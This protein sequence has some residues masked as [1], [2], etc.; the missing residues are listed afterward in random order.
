MEGGRGISNTSFPVCLKSLQLLGR[1][2]FPVI[3]VWLNHI[4]N[5][6]PAR[7]ASVEGL[8]LIACRPYCRF[9]N[10][11]LGRKQWVNCVVYFGENRALRLVCLK[12]L[13][14]ALRG[15]MLWLVPSRYRIRYQY[16]WRDVS[17]RKCPIRDKS[18]WVIFVVS[19]AL[20][21]VSLMIFCLMLFYWF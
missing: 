16:M 11:F 19:F 4:Y 9:I 15:F 18:L 5:F 8:L 7:S 1:A 3:Y 13:R 21:K 10:K 2:L 12:F 14:H 6:S 17:W 20:S